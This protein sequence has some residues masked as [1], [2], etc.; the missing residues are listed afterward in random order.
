M[1]VTIRAHE[2]GVV[3]DHFGGARPGEVNHSLM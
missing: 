3:S 2:V 1:N